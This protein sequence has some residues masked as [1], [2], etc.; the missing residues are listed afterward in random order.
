[1]NTDLIIVTYNSA[2][3]IEKCIDAIDTHTPSSYQIIVV[4]NGST[5]DT[6]NLLKKLP[7]V[8][9]IENDIN[10]GYARA[11]NRGIRQGTSETIAVMNPDVF[12]TD[13]WLTPLHELLWS[14]EKNAIVA[15]KL[16]NS[17]NQLVGVGTNWDWSAPYF[18]LPNKPGLLEEVR[19][20][21]AINGAC[22]LLKRQL[23]DTIGLLDEQYF[24]Y[25]EETDYCFN[26]NYCGY[27][28]LFCPASTVIHEYYP[29]RK[30][31]RQF[32]NTGYKARQSSTA[33]GAT[34][35]TG[36]LPKIRK[37]RSDWR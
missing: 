20:C 13:G 31:I 28:V 23:L 11:V 16:I 15:P 7:H 32:I 30:G 34:G 2:P 22:F 10:A 8:E 3:Y 4:D 25:F 1:M 33:N 21:M 12:V 36:L 18:M 29:N 9:L 27:R 19:E 37:S 24:H 26:A 35:A 17:A 5:D 14:D 6:V